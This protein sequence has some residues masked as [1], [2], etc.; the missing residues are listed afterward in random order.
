V[1]IHGLEITGR[2]PEGSRCKREESPILLTTAVLLNWKK[3]LKDFG[4]HVLQEMDW[5]NK[6]RFLQD[7]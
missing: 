6:E 2:Y 1:K 3:A 5:T 4:T 7:R